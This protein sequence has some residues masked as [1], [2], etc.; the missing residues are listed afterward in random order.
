MIV[1]DR[2]TKVHREGGRRVVSLREVSLRIE[3]GEYVAIMGPSGSGKS[4]LLR[5]LGG[6]DAP[7]PGP[8][9][10]SAATWPG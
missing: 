8:C 2:V 3:P 4:T 5:L 1:L 7:T 9:G 10:S 6:L